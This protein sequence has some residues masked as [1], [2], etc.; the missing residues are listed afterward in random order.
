MLTLSGAHGRRHGDRHHC[1]TLYFMLYHGRKSCPS[2]P[3]CPRA[4][5]DYTLQSRSVLLLTPRV[6]VCALCA[7]TRIPG[8]LVCREPRLNFVLPPP[9][10]IGWWNVYISFLRRPLF[11]DG[12][13]RRHRD[14]RDQVQGAARSCRSSSPV[15]VF[16]RLRG[17]QRYHR[18]R[19]LLK[20]DH[21]HHSSGSLSIYR[22]DI[23]SVESR[24]RALGDARGHD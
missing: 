14:P 4:C 7:P 8:R 17:T 18:G 6:Y 19:E 16:L 15:L 13:I 2:L 20:R 10:A 22:L 3:V 1:R 11:L 21:C 5:L 9:L 23:I 24:R 12:L